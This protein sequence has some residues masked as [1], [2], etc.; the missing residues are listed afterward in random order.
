M[1]RVSGAHETAICTRPRLLPFG[2]S[3]FCF[4]ELGDRGTNERSLESGLSVHVP[5]SPDTQL[6]SQMYILSPGDTGKFAVDDEG[7]AG[8]TRFEFGL[9]I[10]IW[11]TS[12]EFWV[13]SQ[14][15][16]QTVRCNL[17]NQRSSLELVFALTVLVPSRPV[18]LPRLHDDFYPL[19]YRRTVSKKEPSSPLYR[20]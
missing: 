4:C 14:V 2:A 8:G 3:L 10:E 18:S 16:T 13:R 20:N 1:F 7:S 17:Q 9:V 11:G 15:I 5:S 6:Q 12:K 19:E